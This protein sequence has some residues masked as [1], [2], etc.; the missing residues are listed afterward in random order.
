MTVTLP[1]LWS[2]SPPFPPTPTPV[3]EIPWFFIPLLSFPG[4]VLCLVTS[5]RM[6]PRKE[7][8][9]FSPSFKVSGGSWDVLI[10]ENL[11]FSP[12]ELAPGLEQGFSSIILHLVCLF[13]SEI[14]VSDTNF[15]FKGT[16]FHKIAE[17]I[18]AK[19]LGLLQLGDSMVSMC[20]VCP[21][22]LD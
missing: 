19:A 9:T 17:S 18:K 1:A 21:C 15:P 7:T 20:V 5:G 11:A 16:S 6:S 3:A 2:S 22:H 4:K 14:L 12:R 13:I 10:L 8:F